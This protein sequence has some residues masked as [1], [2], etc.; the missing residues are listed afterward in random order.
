MTQII[1]GLP[2]SVRR[3][4]TA[5]SFLYSSGSRSL[6]PIDR[7]IALLGI[8]SN[9]G[10][11]AVATPTEVFDTV[12][13]DTLAGVGSELA[14]MARATFAQFQR[15]GRS[16]HLFLVT[17]AEPGAG[18]ARVVT[19]TV[20]GPATESGTYI[21]RIAGRPITFGV[22]AGDTAN[23]VAA[24]LKAAIDAQGPILPLTAAVVGAVVTVTLRYKG[25]N[26]NDVQFREEQGIAG[27]AVAYAQTTAG[28][29]TVDLTASLDTLMQ[30]FDG[31]VTANGDA[32]DVTD[33]STHLAACNTSTAKKWRRGWMCEPGSIGAATV[34][35]GSFNDVAAHVLC[36]EGVESLPGEVAG[37]MAAS[38]HTATRPNP[39]LNGRKI[40][41]YPPVTSLAFT[42][43]EQETALGVG[44]T[45]FV[46]VTT[47]SGSQVDGLLKLVKLTTTKTLEGAV[48][49]EWPRLPAVSQVGWAIA[50]QI[51]SKFAERFGPDANP[52][53]ALVDGTIR[54]RVRDLVVD[55][56]YTAEEA[57]WVRD[58]DD[59]LPAILVEIDGSVATRVNTALEYVPVVPLDQAAFVHRVS[60]S[61]SLNR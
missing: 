53:G 31:V 45:P 8:K 61:V 30:K 59:V 26:G 39:N 32:N 5:H 16:C 47:G 25:A 10:T 1:T 49:V 56:L 50:E 28:A 44:V 11:L 41:A 6:V 22:T 52:D 21:Y 38:Y 19:L 12:T 20:T 57:T 17:I 43:T 37:A 7:R 14:L 27:I 40:V 33:L 46:P 35:A 54:G 36:C 9:A 23:T 13:S 48:P 55:V 29:G 34:H 51:D 4:L 24:A 15:E 18:A 2:S 60:Q 58:V 3:P 42:E